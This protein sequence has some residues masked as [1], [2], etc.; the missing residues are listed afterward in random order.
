M[1]NGDDSATVIDIDYIVV[2]D[3]VFFVFAVVRDGKCSLLAVDR[4]HVVIGSRR[5]ETARGTAMSSDMII[6]DIFRFEPRAALGTVN[7]VAQCPVGRNAV[8]GLFRRNAE[9]RSVRVVREQS[10][11]DKVVRVQNDFHAF[12]KLFVEDIADKIGMR[13]PFQRIAHDVVANEYIRRQILIHFQRTA[14][15]NFKHSDLLFRLSGKGRVGEE[16]GDNAL[17][18]IRAVTVVRDGISVVLQDRGKQIADRRFPVRAGDAYKR[19][20]LF[21]MSEEIGTDPDRDGAR[22]MG[23][24]ASADA[25]KAVSQ[26]CRRHSEIKAYF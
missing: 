20:G 19:F 25:E 16:R 5:R 22:S 26:F 3:L 1:K 21:Q 7:D 17:A 10:R 12:G 9:I 2:Y 18:Y 24:R 4:G 13:V 11:T 14:L 6:S 8:L 23:R 15:V